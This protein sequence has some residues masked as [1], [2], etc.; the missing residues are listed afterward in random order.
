MTHHGP[1]QSH[2]FYN[3]ENIPDTVTDLISNLSLISLERS[4]CVG[5]QHL[6]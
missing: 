4:F 6:L 5:A 3:F 2:P 1:F